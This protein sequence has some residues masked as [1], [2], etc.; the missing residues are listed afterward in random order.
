MLE[1]TGLPGQNGFYYFGW[2]DKWKFKWRT[3]H[4][5][6]GTYCATA[7]SSLAGQELTAPEIRLR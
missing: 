3:S 7:T 1:R 2:F 4:L 5:P 6:P